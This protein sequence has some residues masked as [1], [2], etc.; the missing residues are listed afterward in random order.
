VTTELEPFDPDDVRRRTVPPTVA[1]WSPRVHA[2]ASQAIHGNVSLNELLA[3][4]AD[5]RNRQDWQDLRSAL[6]ETTDQLIADRVTAPTWLDDDARNARAALRDDDLDSALRLLA[7]AELRQRLVDQDPAGADRGPGA[8]V[9]RDPAAVDESPAAQDRAVS[10][11]WRS[12]MTAAAEL[13]AQGEQPQDR[14][15]GTAPAEPLREEELTMLDRV[16]PAEAET[17]RRGGGGRGRDWS[18]RRPERAGQPAT[19]RQPDRML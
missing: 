11:L 18:H 1:G 14:T 3:D 10:N 19:A 8:V 17:A 7:D 2:L 5:A 16:D 15:D 4:R 9:D 12:D 6:Q 13:R